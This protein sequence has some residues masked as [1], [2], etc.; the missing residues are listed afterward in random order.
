MDLLILIARLRDH[1]ARRRAVHERHRMVRS[2]ARAGRRRRGIRARRGRHRAARDDDPDHRHPVRVRARRRTR[3]GS[4]P[5]SGAPFMLATLAMF[6]T[7]VAVLYQ[8]PP[9]TDRRH[10]EGRHGRPGARHALLRDRL[11][12][13]DRRRVPAARAGLA[14]MDR[15]GRPHRHL[16]LVRQGPFRGRRRGRTPRTSP[17]SASIAWTGTPIASTLRATPARRQPAGRRGARPDRPRSGLLRERGRPHRDPVQRRQHAP[18]PRHRTDRDGAAREVQLDHLGPPGQGHPGDGQHHRA[19]WSS[20]PASRRSSRSLFASSSWVVAQGSYVAFASAGDRL[21]VVGG[22][23]HPDGPSRRPARQ[24]LL[25]GGCFY[26]VYLGLVI[27]VITG[28]VGGGAPAT[29]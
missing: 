3:S 9:A 12:A 18:G 20:S 6:V 2:E 29:H 10:D 27:G 25:V 28:E 24:L 11:R 19:R 22:D 26:L 14:E 5:S 13:G 1:P 23:L 17:R 16:R 7:G 8:A 21:P 4:G 15:G